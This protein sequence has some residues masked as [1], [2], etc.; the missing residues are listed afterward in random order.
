M[1]STYIF[2]PLHI[3][4]VASG[5]PNGGI[6]SGGNGFYATHYKI[7]QKWMLLS[8]IQTAMESHIIKKNQKKHLMTGNMCCLSI[9]G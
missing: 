8:L 2:I 1:V 9:C 6:P 5:I 3:I 4:Q 7:A